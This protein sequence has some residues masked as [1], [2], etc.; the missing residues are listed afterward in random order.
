MLSG[1]K[2]FGARTALLP[3]LRSA[4]ALTNKRKAE[5]A[6]ETSSVYVASSQT[7]TP[8]LSTL[9]HLV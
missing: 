3:G 9:P 2:V 5:C 6:L 4:A 8:N 1:P 7:I